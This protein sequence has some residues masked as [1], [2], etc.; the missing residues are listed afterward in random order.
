MEINA[1]KAFVA[2]AETQSFSLA[3]ER[4]FITQ[5]AVSKRVGGMEEELGTPLFDRAGRRVR[6]TEAGE[7]LLPRARQ[8]LKELEDMRQSIASLGDAVGGRLPMA[9][10]HHIGLHRLPPALRGF[11]RRYPA[12]ELDIQFMES[13][14]ACRQV[15]DWRLDLAVVTLSD[16]AREHLIAVELWNDPLFV[17]VH[18]DHPLARLTSATLDDLLEH[19]A[20]LPDKGTWT[21]DLVERAIVRAGG[22]LHV[23]M[24]TNYL[25]T[26]A[27]LVSIGVGWSL[28]PESLARRAEFVVLHID[29]LKLSRSL[30]V[31]HHPDRSLPRAARAML[32][33]LAAGS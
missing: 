8:L 26:L 23:S 9:T 22:K 33:I 17:S 24:S 15:H 18:R 2:V 31:V 25:E 12:V 5:P 21:R 11:V 29:A 20:V 14:S 28:L 1:L 32:E 13:E 16:W 4:L 27:M 3:A 19:P 30:G 7:L 10:S 6:L